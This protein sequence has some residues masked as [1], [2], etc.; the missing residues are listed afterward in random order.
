MAVVSTIH[1]FQ[2]QIRTCSSLDSWSYP[3]ILVFHSPGT[4]TAYIIQYVSDKNDLN[5]KITSGRRKKLHP[6]PCL[7]PY[8]ATSKIQ[9][10][11]QEGVSDWWRKFFI[12]DRDSLQRF[13]SWPYLK[14]TL[15]DMVNFQKGNKYSDLP[16]I[17]SWKVNQNIRWQQ[18]IF[19]FGEFLLI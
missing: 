4:N 12:F 18:T 5:H 8:P 2:Q 3:K 14:L 9:L 15:D 11:C 16:A 13:T 6:R 17:K 1:W 10:I 19:G 7:W